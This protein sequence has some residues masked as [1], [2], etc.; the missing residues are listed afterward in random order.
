MLIIS[1]LY[2]GKSNKDKLIDVAKMEIQNT[3]VTKSTFC[4]EYFDNTE[5]NDNKTDTTNIKKNAAFIFNF[6]ISKLSMKV[7]SRI[8][9]KPKYWVKLSFSSTIK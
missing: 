2:C 8:I 7:E 5:D 4:R 9:P 6:L 3:T 1:I